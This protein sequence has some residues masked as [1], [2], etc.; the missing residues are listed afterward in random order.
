MVT[1]GI[2]SILI[3]GL[4]LWAPWWLFLLGVVGGLVV[5]R[6]YVVAIVYGLLYD[7]LYM[8]HLV[9][10]YHYYMLFL[11]LL[12]VA[13]IYYFRKRLFVFHEAL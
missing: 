8:P 7:L 9:G 5:Y 11:I 6:L 2:A 3:L 12:A 1:R 10:S 13:V 4:L